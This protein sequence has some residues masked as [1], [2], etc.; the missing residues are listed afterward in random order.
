MTKEEY[1]KTLFELNQKFKKEKY[2]LAKEFALSNNDV[3]IGDIVSDGNN[4]ISVSKFC[5]D[6][7][8]PNPIPYV[9]YKGIKLTKKLKPFKTGELGVVYDIKEKI[10]KEE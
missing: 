6:F 2:K 5:I 7:G 9:Y 10:S 1:E 4:M 8:Y 3:K